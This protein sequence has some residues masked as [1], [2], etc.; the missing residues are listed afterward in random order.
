MRV[1]ATLGLMTVMLLAPAWAAEEPPLPTSCPDCYK[2][3]PG[4]SWQIQFQR[5]IDT[6][7]RA[8]FFDIDGDESANTVTALKRRGRKVVL[9]EGVGARAIPL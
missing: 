6:S 5:R 1:V 9:R 3:R 4:T 7:V 2:P 8:R